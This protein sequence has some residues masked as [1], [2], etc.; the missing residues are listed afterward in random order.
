MWDLANK[1]NSARLREHI[2]DKLIMEL[3]RDATF[4]DRAAR[5]SRYIQVLRLIRDAFHEMP[6]AESQM[7]AILLDIKLQAYNRSSRSTAMILPI[8]T[9]RQTADEIL[10][11]H[12]FRAMNRNAIFATKVAQGL[13][14]LLDNS[15]QT[16]NH[17]GQQIA[18]MKNRAREP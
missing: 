14:R 7:V 17:S 8:S 13:E 16:H 4:K 12:V 11:G 10:Q 1:Y 18:T 3:S 9:D 6:R 5:T 15:M 2:A